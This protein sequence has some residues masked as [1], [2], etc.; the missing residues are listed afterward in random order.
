MRTR[1]LLPLIIWLALG[2]RL[3]ALG[4]QSLWYDE[5][6]TWYLTR[7]DLPALIRWT[8]DDIQPPFYYIILWCSSRL[9]GQSEF[10]LRFPSVVFGLLGVP[11]MWQVG[12]T[13]FA[14]WGRVRA[15]GIG[16]TAAALMAFSPLMVYYSQE[17]RMYTLLVFQAAVGSYLLWRIA[18][19]AFDTATSVG[20]RR[21]IVARFRSTGYVIVMASALYTHYF[22]AF[23]LLAHAVYMVVVLV[24]ADWPRP[25]VG[26]CLLIVG[27]VLLLFVPWIPVL[28]A[29]LGDDPS[30]W[31]GLLKLPEIVQDVAISFA[32]GGKREMILEADGLPLA[33]IFGLLLLF[34]IVALWFTLKKSPRPPGPPAP[35]LF[36]LLWLI[37]PITLILLLSYQTPKFNP[38]YTM[39]SWPAFALLLAGGLGILWQQKGRAARLGSM[40]MLLFIGYSWAFSLRNWYTDEA[41]R[42]DDFKALAQFVRER[43]F[44]NE[45][46]LLSSGH[47]F[48]VWQYYFGLDN[49][50]AL[51]ELETLDVERVTDFSITPSLAEAL[52]GQPGVWLVTWQDE[53]IDPNQVIPLLL[54]TVGQRTEDPLLIGDFIGVGL[55]YWHLPQLPTV[56][57]QYPVTVPTEVNFGNLVR[58]HGLWQSDEAEAEIA[59]YWEALQ[60]LTEDYLISLRL[61]DSAGVDWSDGGQVTRPGAYFYPSPALADRRDCG[62]PA[63][64]AFV[65][66]HPPRPILA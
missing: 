34:N 15:E 23:L 13:V 22:A 44:H 12:Q 30:Y 3:V 18:G 11:L 1:R 48:P 61:L 37:L 5:G 66:R 28:M 45:P 32:V 58:L 54:D 41:F 26:Q 8:A 59:L 63:V 49:W 47:F 35:L 9:F 43:S 27:G 53:V 65:D 14:A 33:A 57:Q 20:E 50:T 60:P 52:A 62:R 38:R 16:L 2:L 10:A 31:P 39:L 6:V 17:A 7:F 46:V 4:A 51:P 36:L 42:R 56:P 29:R 64:T 40:L 21:S 55:R 19:R 24:K 25:F